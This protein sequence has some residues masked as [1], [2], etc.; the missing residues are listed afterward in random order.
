MLPTNLTVNPTSTHFSFNMRKLARSSS[1]FETW[2]II[3]LWIFP[4]EF[5]PSLLEHHNETSLCLQAENLYLKGAELE[6]NNNYYD[7]IRYYRRALQL[8][9]DIE[10]KVLKNSNFKD[11][12][13]YNEDDKGSIALINLCSK[14][15]ARTVI[16]LYYFRK[17][18]QSIRK[19]RKFGRRGCLWWQWAIGSSI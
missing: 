8:V 18:L 15:G 14:N 5:N 19:W 17:P 2:E 9:P 13:K 11:G 3:F 16:I 10:T 6:R 4:L 7:A 12:N 1:I